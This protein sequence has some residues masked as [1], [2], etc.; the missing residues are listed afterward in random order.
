MQFLEAEET[1]LLHSIL[2]NH[3][4]IATESA[5]ADMLINCG[6]SLLLPHLSSLGKSSLLFVNELCARLSLP[7]VVAKP[8][9]QPGLVALLNYIA[10]PPY[11]ADL[12]L[13]EK[14]FLEA[15]KQKCLQWH[16]SQRR[17]PPS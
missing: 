4:L 9:Q 14:R 10:L 7:H 16:T 1:S 5:R 13:E 3:V 12:T 6:L 2:V 17:V 8:S 15:V 11:D